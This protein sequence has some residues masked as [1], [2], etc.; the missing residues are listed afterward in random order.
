MFGG[1]G[2]SGLDILMIRNHG[3]HTPPE[4]HRIEPQG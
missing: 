4:A 1:T 3:A 2:Y